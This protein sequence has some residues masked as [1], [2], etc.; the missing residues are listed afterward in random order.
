M[1]SGDANVILRCS[2]P[3]DH[4]QVIALL[5]ESGLPVAGVAEWFDRFVVA[6]EGGDIVG[7]A[8]LEVH[9][10]DGLLRS[11]AVRAD[12]RGSGLGGALTE[13][14][15]ARSGD[16]LKSIYLLTE[17]AEAFFPRHGFRRIARAAASDAVK[18]SAE[19]SE[20]CPVSAVLM[21]RTMPAT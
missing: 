11:V 7:V 2:R 6:D 16:G 21:I 19:F 4:D 15:I 3:E 20:L 10:V 1:T 17:T 9:G 12:H 13:E 5:A 14:V 18:R 8:G